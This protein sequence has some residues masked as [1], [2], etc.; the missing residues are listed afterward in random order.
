[1]DT[2]LPSG[3]SSLLII[4]AL[5]PLALFLINKKDIKINISVDDDFENKANM[6]Q[7]IKPYFSES[8]QSILCKV[9]DV[10]DILNK[11]NRMNKS[12][13]NGEIK[14]L[15]TQI[16]DIDRREIILTEI[17]KFMHGENKERAEKVMA[18]KKSIFEVKNNLDNYK[19]IMTSEKVI[20]GSSLVKL[21]NSFEPILN[22]EY[23]EKIRKIEKVIG[24]VNNSKG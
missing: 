12:D 10:F 22:D 20:K 19:E 5:I 4:G 1:M 2:R 9:Q 18:A 14:E 3:N 13:Y 23:K 24:I 21:M 17:S 8:E 11:I 7:N 16:S 15:S 6:I